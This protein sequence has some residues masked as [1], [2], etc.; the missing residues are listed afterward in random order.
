MPILV[1]NLLVCLSYIK[2]KNCCPA[3]AAPVSR[4][5]LKWG[6]LETSVQR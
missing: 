2:H 5:T 3:A 4:W 1:D 6:G